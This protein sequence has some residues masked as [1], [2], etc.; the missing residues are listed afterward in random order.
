MPAAVPRPALL[1]LTLSLGVTTLSLMQS[2][3]VPILS[4][5]GAQL[6]KVGVPSSPGLAEGPLV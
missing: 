5:I 4:T 1:V 2:L 3:V 6:E